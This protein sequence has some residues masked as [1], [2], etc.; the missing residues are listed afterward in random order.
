MLSVGPCFIG[1]KT[2]RL[3][4][5]Y[6]YL[7]GFL[8]VNRHPQQ[9]SKQFQER[10]TVTK[11]SSLISVIC[12]LVFS[13]T[14]KLCHL[15]GPDS[16]PISYHPFRARMGAQ[17]SAHGCE[18]RQAAL[19]F[20][21]QH[22][23]AVSKPMDWDDIEGFVLE[24]CMKNTILTHLNKDRCSL[25]GSRTH[26]HPRSVMKSW[27]AFKI[28]KC[29][30]ASGGGTPCCGSASRDS[31]L[32]HVVFDSK[33]RPS[34]IHLLNLCTQHDQHVVR[35]ERED[36]NNEYYMLH[37]STCLVG[38]VRLL[39]RALFAHNFGGGQASALLHKGFRLFLLLSP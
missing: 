3:V 16:D 28:R 37:G 17:A 24:N 30:V 8:Q 32:Q 25:G 20:I 4:M 9:S 11:S 1:Q 33:L 19:N 6:L 14:E 29:R 15:S 18:H 22:L 5:K 7:K 13:I 2:C 27:K 10:A 39:R 38:G 21:E 31:S 23:P 34:T 35:R 26:P 12:S 36:L